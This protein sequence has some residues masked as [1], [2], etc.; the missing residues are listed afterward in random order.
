MTERIINTTGQGGQRINSNRQGRPTRAEREQLYAQM[1]EY[2]VKG[3]SDLRIA[4]EV[5]VCDRTVRRW[6]F[7]EN[8]QNVYGRFPTY[9]G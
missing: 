6:R 4:E 9:G 8:L 2:Y 5:G 1:W 3:Y 7:R